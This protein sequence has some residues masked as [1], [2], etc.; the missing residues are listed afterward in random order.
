MAWSLSYSTRLGKAM[1]GV[2]HL[3]HAWSDLWLCGWPH[4]FTALD[5]LE[6]KAAYIQEQLSGTKEDFLCVQIP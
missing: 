2:A 3:L 1:A 4:Y 6:Q 5:I